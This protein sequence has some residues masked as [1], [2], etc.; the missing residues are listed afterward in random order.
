MKQKPTF[1]VDKKGLAKI[2]ARRGIEFVVLELIQNA[3]DEDVDDIRVFLEKVPNRHG[4]YAITVNDN[5]PE[6]FKDLSHAYTLFAESLKGKNPEQRGR[7][8]LGE[9]LVIAACERATIATTQGTVEFTGEGRVHRRKKRER[10][11][12]FRGELRLKP[13]QVEAIRKA[14]FQVLVPEGVE[15]RFNGHLVYSRKPT[16]TFEATLPTEIADEEGYLRRTERKTRVEVYESVGENTLYEMGIPVVPIECAWH[17]NVCQKVPLNT[18]RDNVTPAY[19]RRLLTLVLNETHRKLDE[20]K[21]RSPWVEEALESRDITEEAVESVVTARYGDRR[22]IADPSDPEGTK[23]A[24][25]RGY[26]VIQAGSFSKAQWENI[27]RAGAALPAGKVTPSPKAWSDDPDAPVAE[28]YPPDE[29]T[30]EMRQV[31][32]YSRR[33]AGL[34]L[35]LNHLV[36]RMAK[37]ANGF[38]ACYGKVNGLT[39]NVRA[40]GKAWFGRALGDVEKLDRLLIHE[41]AHHHVSDHLSAEYHEELCRLGAKLKALALDG[42]LDNLVDPRIENGLLEAESEEARA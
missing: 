7:F 19:L 35:E 25:S 24:V 16:V 33:M 29:W 39:F 27:K 40:L 23:L 3:L 9:K 20:E 38:A 42:E 30:T 22:V 8:N 28:F 21:L 15:M 36:V 2:L 13:D 14:V 34:L 6:G 32:A 37:T 41:F 12:T 1:E 4:L 10:G 26:Q 5:N 11:T 18:D 17:V 31:A